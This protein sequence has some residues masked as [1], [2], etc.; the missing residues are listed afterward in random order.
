VSAP[1]AEVKI[2]AAKVLANGGRPMVWTVP[3]APDCDE[4]GLPGLAEVFGL[5][6]RS[7]EC[8]NHTEHVPF[9][10]V[11]YSSQTMEEYGRGDSG[12]FSECQ[13]EF[14]GALALARHTHLP[15]DIILDDRVT[16]ERLLRYRVLVLPNSAA[17]SEAQCAG[18]RAFVQ[19]GGGLVA[20]FETSLHDERGQRRRDFG[21]ADVLGASFEQEL[22]RQDARWSTGYAVVER[23][24]PVTG[25]FEVGFRLPA[26]GR[27]LGVKE[28]AATR[29]ST[30]LTRCRYYC[31]YPGQRTGHPGLLAHEFGRGRVVYLPGQFGLTY[32]ERGFPDYR[33]LFCDAIEWLSRGEVP[34][35]TTLP[36]TVEVTLARTATGALVLHLVNCFAD[37][38][39]PVE[40][41]APITGDTVQLRVPHPR[42]CVAHALA[43]GIDLPCRVD[44]DMATIALPP[45]AEYEVVVLRQV[46]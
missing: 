45:L 7:P 39:R 18:I 20:T 23:K 10:G 36:D 40:R 46:T 30:M 5:A 14:S 24:H 8:F 13:R 34:I 15:T 19:A 41:V 42:P 1:P 3:R 28:T 26:G 27:H 21:L 43:A 17:L 6:S 4:R 2:K 35:R 12:R 32:S 9:L 37:L 31:D 33:R 29:L 25:P 16:A 38:S 11:L 22:V 44:G